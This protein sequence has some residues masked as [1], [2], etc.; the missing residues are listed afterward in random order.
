MINRQLKR[1]QYLQTDCKLGIA[2]IGFGAFHRA[3]QA[4]YIDDLLHKKDQQHWAIVA[5]N[6]LKENNLI[7]DQFNAQ[8]QHYI[9]KTTTADGKEEFREIGSIKMAINH[10]EEP[11]RC[12]A[13]FV[14]EDIRVI[15]MTITEDAYYFD[16]N[17]HLDTTHPIIA[18]ELAQK[19]DNTIYGFLRSVLMKRKEANQPNLSI[20][21]C[22]NLIQNSHHLKQGLIKFLQLCGEHDLVSWVESN[23]AFPATMV[24]RITP[25]Y[26]PIYSK[27][28]KQYFNYDDQMTIMS[29]SYIEWIIEDCF[30]DK[31]PFEKVNFVEDVTAYEKS[32]VYILNGGHTALAYQSAMKRIT[33][34]DQ[35]I[36]DEELSIFFD[37]F[38]KNEVIPSLANYAVLDHARY[39]GNI[40]E[41]FS[42]SHIQDTVERICMNGFSKIQNCIM[43][44]L[45]YNLEQGYTPKYCI[46]ILASWYVFMLLAKENRLPFQ[47]IDSNW[48]MLYPKIQ[49]NNLDDFMDIRLLW[50]RLPEKYPAFVT[51][52]QSKVKEIQTRFY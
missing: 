23:I 8:N 39:V 35:A 45:T 26:N 19:T 49:L 7:V 32:K 28:V 43:P 48:A 14:K 27:E 38:Q 16:K 33:T 9:L 22:D 36:R 44:T 47:Y 15:T 41:R 52:L 5:I 4:V 24:D 2:H 30:N 12:Y 6:L 20:L 37:Q 1:F 46:E 51:L 34:I 10:K 18:K 42:N 17:Y 3:H 31:P 29:E 21:S 11:D 50:G 13:L 40:K 25:A